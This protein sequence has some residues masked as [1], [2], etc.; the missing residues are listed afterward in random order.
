MLAEIF[1]SLF[2]EKKVTQKTF[3][4][5]APHSLIRSDDE[6]SEPLLLKEKGSGINTL[7]LEGLA[8]IKGFCF[9]EFAPLHLIH[10]DNA[11]LGMNKKLLLLFVYF[12]LPVLLIFPISA[13]LSFPNTLA[14]FTLLAVIGCTLFPGW[15]IMAI[16]EFKFPREW[17]QPMWYQPDYVLPVFLIAAVVLL[18]LFL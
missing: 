10:E 4:K 11:Y 15:F 18:R 8:R 7:C 5:Y 9:A 1:L 3:Q 13:L 17:A 2:L 14:F 16:S 12:F 6:T